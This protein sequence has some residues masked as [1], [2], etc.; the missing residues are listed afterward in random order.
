MATL[1]QI[2]SPVWTY[3]IF[4][5]GA[6][7]EGLA[8]IRQ[9]ID[10]IIRTTKGS[11]PLRPEFGSD[12]YKYQDYPANAGI[13]NIK[14]AI[15]DAI[16]TWE[17]RVVITYIRHTLEL[18]N[19]ILEIGYKLVDDSLNDIILVTIGSG[20]VSTGIN[21]KRL[22]L[23]GYIP[24]NPSNYQYQV[25]CTLNSVSI[26]PAP[27]GDGFADVFELYAWVQTNWLNYGQWYLTA[28]SLVGYMNPI[29]TTGSLSISLLT[30]NK[31]F[32][33]ITGIPVGYKYH[34]VIVV[35]GKTF[36]STTNLYTADQIRQWAQDNIGELGSWS[37]GT[38]PG[39]FSDDFSDDFEVFTQSL[40]IYTALAKVVTITITTESV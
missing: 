8:A 36:T 38:L 13:A 24:P 1:S 2:K 25:A 3:S 9:C 17:K 18:S 4:G 21:I 20:G 35:D 34:V 27:P 5:G 30:K 6:I 37:I 23:Q 19:L 33:A 39:S 26:L 12:V 7:S 22:I 16:K 14:K 15:L 31:F 10:I 28:E 40:V 32:G 29:Y 11:D